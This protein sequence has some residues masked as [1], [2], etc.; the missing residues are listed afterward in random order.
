MR[1]EL[2]ESL[3]IPVSKVRVLTEYMGGGFG[4]KFGPRVEGVAAARL[5][6]EAGAPVK[7]FLDRK[8]E[9]TR[10]RQPPLLGPDGSRRGATK[11]GKLTALQLTVHGTGGT[12]GGTGTSGPIK[13]IYAC[14]NLKVEE[15]DVFTN[16]GPS[17]AM[18][19]PGHPQGAF[20]LEATMDELA[21][22]LGMDPLELRMKND[23]SAVRRE[24]FR[25]RRREDRLEGPRRAPARPRT[26]ASVPR[27]RRRRGGLVQHRRHGTPGHRHD[28][29]RRL[30]EVEHGGQDLGTGARGR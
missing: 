29:P 28:P 21:R 3:K 11:D 25:D 15:Y 18:R 27:R 10:H 19:A 14:E 23:P 24:E 4:A 16:A 20:A 8:E 30:A 7:L 9:Q 5:A 17:T 22:Q 6:E 26:P 12:N 2:A 1:D 13:N